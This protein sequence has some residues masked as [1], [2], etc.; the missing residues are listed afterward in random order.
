MTLIKTE[1]G[2]ETAAVIDRDVENNEMVGDKDRQRN[3]MWLLKNYLL[4]NSRFQSK[5][6][7]QQ[8]QQHQ[9]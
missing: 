1:K 9:R 5:K 8:Q 4:M 6:Q 2:S 7:Q 3:E